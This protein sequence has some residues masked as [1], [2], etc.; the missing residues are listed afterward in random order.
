MWNIPRDPNTGY[1]KTWNQLADEGY[2][3]IT[4]KDIPSNNKSLLKF[5][6]K[7]FGGLADGVDDLII[8][9]SPLA[10]E[11][12][13]VRKMS[14]ELGGIKKATFG[15]LQQGIEGFLTKVNDE[16]IPF[17]L[18]ELTSPNPKKVFRIIK[19]NSH[20]IKEGFNNGNEMIVRYCKFDNLNTY[21]RLDLKN[22]SYNELIKYY[23]SI[24]VNRRH[25][26]FG[27]KVY[28]EIKIICKD[29]RTIIFDN[30]KLIE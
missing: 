12:V 27:E 22:I 11:L 5:K 20:K 13:Q 16:F 10:H 15:N 1:P 3:K 25:L 4:I 26:L 29:K 24:P 30:Y 2:I 14:E 18:K 7:S 17:S 9:G 8:D 6:G 19:E 21:I 23:Q 28:K